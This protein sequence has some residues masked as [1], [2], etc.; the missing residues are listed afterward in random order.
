MRAQESIDFFQRGREPLGVRV[1]EVPGEDQVVAA[2][3]DG[4]SA[5]FM[6]RALSAFPRRRNPSASFPPVGLVLGG[7][8]LTG[9]ARKRAA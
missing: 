3:L 5:M 9:V 7:A 4:P 2:F 6:N 8:P 1:G